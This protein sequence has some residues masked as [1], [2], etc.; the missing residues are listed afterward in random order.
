MNSLNVVSL[1]MEVGDPLTNQAAEIAFTEVYYDSVVLDLGLGRQCLLASGAQFV[2]AV[3][4]HANEL[5][6]MAGIIP[7]DIDEQAHLEVLAVKRAHQGKGIGSFL[8]H[9]IEQQVIQEGAQSLT[10]K[11]T[12]HSAAFYERLGYGPHPVVGDLLIKGLK[13]DAQANRFDIRG[14]YL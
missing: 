3:P 10:L 1:P 2:G 5:W 9:T 13:E 14:A 8:L 11:P 4:G 7:P 6:A 12:E